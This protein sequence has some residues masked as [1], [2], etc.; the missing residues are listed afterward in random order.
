MAASRLSVTI[1]RVLPKHIKVPQRQTLIYMAI[2]AG[3]I[4]LS[5]LTNKDRPVSTGGIVTFS[6]RSPSEEPTDHYN[7]QGGA[8]EPKYIDLP[9]I[10]SGGFI[11]RVGVDQN[12]Q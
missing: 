12:R 6:S 4:G 2:I 9:S 10:H 7:W 5:A 8:D 1:Y 11:Q 3:L